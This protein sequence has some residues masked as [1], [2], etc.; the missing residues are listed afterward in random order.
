MKASL[1]G[2][3]NFVWKSCFWTWN[4][5]LIWILNSVY[6]FVQ[7]LQSLD[8]KFYWRS[9]EE[10]WVLW[11]WTK[12][13]IWKIKNVM[14][15]KHLSITSASLGTVQQLSN[16]QLSKGQLSKGQLSKE[17]V[18]QED[19]CPRTTFVQGD[20]C[21]SRLFSKETVTLFIVQGRRL[22]I[23]LDCRRTSHHDIVR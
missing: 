5:L 14:V 10:M 21:P 17:T 2:I 19:Y 20:Y 16:G 8:T 18:V 4:Y 22:R 3:V 6:T 11:W 23:L 12:I 9:M 1:F 7:I 15:W 13:F